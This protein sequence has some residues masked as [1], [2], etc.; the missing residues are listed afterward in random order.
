MKSPKP[1]RR[2][3]LTEIKNY[4]KFLNVRKFPSMQNFSELQ[5]CYNSNTH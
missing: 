1:A 5:S 4:K 2:Q 3:P